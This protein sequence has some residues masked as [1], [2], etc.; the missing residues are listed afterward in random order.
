MMDAIY[1]LIAWLGDL[2]KSIWTAF[3]DF[4][5]D[6]WIDIADIVLQGIAAIVVS[7]PVPSFLSNYSIGQIIGYLPYDVLYFVG[8]MHMGEGFA[9]I[10]A[11]V[12]FRMVRKLITLFQW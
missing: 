3:V 9:L 2:I 8:L 11:A 1:A 6:I 10:S 12:G 4:I 7:I 5:G